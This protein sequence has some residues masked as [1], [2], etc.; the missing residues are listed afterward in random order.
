M[1]VEGC[2]LSVKGGLL[3]VKVGDRGRPEH[4]RGIADTGSNRVLAAE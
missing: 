2:L 4:R 3:A 1:P